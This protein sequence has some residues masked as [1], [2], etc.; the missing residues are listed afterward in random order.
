[1][2]QSLPN[3]AKVAVTDSWDLMEKFKYRIALPA[4][5]LYGQF[6]NVDVD[7]ILT[8]LLEIGFDDV[9]E[10]ALGLTSFQD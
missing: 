9:F 4:P 8:A 10:V 7:S 6:K 5:S 1:M 2:Y 3:H